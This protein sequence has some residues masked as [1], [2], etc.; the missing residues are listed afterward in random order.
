MAVVASIHSF[1][2]E[3]DYNPHMNVCCSNVQYQYISTFVG[4]LF[5]LIVK[6][7]GASLCSR[8]TSAVHVHITL[9]LLTI[10]V[11]SSMLLGEG[12]PSTIFFSAPSI[13]PSKL[14][15]MEIVALHIVLKA[16]L[17]YCI[18]AAHAHSSKVAFMVRTILSSI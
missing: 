3:G 2:D 16:S 8:M 15:Q 9:Q 7:S 18:F 17:V 12:Y 13:Q 5:S 10:V 6:V 11:A 4:S 1:N 14:L